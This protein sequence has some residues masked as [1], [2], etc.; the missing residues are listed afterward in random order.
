LNAAT[1]LALGRDATVN[2]LMR[3]IVPHLERGDVVEVTINRPGELW[4]KTFQGWEPVKVP[5][6]TMPYLKSLANA[7][8]VFN[9]ISLA[10]ITS[11]VLPGGQ[12]GQIVLPPACIDDTLSL[13]IRKHSL[14]VKTLD[15][16][17]A[18]GAFE[19]FDD[20]SFNKPTAAE[21]A[22]LVL[23]RDFTRLTPAE[24][25]LLA[26]NARRSHA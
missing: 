20:V 18:E 9:G 2:Q 19:S 6:L 11:V 23:K 7:I 21:A 16:L 8:A 1:S 22:A 14:V 24:A 4:A 3:P 13:S 10:S 12:R 26:L 17:D 25:E 5:E 15:E